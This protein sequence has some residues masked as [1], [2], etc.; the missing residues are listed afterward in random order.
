MRLIAY[1]RAAKSRE[2]WKL[3]SRDNY[4]PVVWY[5]IP[6]ALINVRPRPLNTLKVARIAT[7]LRPAA[8]APGHHKGHHPK[9]AH[10]PEPAP[11]GG[12]RWGKEPPQKSLFLG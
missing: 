1:R 11:R 6:K 8:L 4:A 9:S 7:K 10:L 3:N 12:W 5:I 2:V